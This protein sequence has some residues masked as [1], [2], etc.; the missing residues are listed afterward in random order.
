MDGSGQERQAGHYQSLEPIPN[1][2]IPCC[3]ISFNSSEGPD[4]SEKASNV[5]QISNEEKTLN[6]FSEDKNMVELSLIRLDNICVSLND[7]FS[8]NISCIL[9]N[10]VRPKYA[11]TTKA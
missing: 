7:L 4:N 5:E 1:Q 6:S 9:Y 10:E 8:T 3:Q 2:A 11:V